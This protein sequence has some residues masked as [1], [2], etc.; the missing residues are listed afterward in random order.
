MNTSVVRINIT[1]PKNLL[2]DLEKEIPK[3]GK[4]GFISKAIEEKLDRERRK[5]AFMELHD[6]PPAFTKIKNSAEYISKMRR[7]D[8]KREKR[9][10]K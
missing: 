6:A 3:R 2:T 4:S 9:L 7:L 8:E 5:T 1:V 10:Y